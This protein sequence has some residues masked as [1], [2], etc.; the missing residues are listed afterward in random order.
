MR[1][2]PATDDMRVPV[3]MI[4]PE[5]AVVSPGTLERLRLMARLPHVYHHVAAL[6][7]VS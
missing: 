5:E 4:C 7:D 3:Q 2:I 6:P 1:V